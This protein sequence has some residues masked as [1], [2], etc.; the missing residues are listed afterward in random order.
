LFAEALLL[1]LKLWQP[2]SEGE[3]PINNEVCHTFLV[4]LRAS[5]AHLCQ[6]PNEASIG[7]QEDL[8][9]FTF[10]VSRT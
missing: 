9:R 10:A 2:K 1:S 6:L 3:L 7:D 8:S 4:A 5:V